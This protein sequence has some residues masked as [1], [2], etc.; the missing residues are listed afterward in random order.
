MNVC[1]YIEYHRTNLLDPK[2]PLTHPQ[3]FA[4]LLQV[5]KTKKQLD[6]RVPQRNG[7]AWLVCGQGMN[8]TMWY[9]A[10]VMTWKNN[11]H[12]GLSIKPIGLISSQ[13]ADIKGI[14]MVY[15]VIDWDIFDAYWQDIT[16]ESLGFGEK[17]WPSVTQPDRCP[18]V[19]VHALRDTL[20]MKK[21]GLVWTQRA[22]YCDLNGKHDFSVGS[23]SPT[24]WIGIQ[25]KMGFV[26]IYP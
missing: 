8:L 14:F 23:R 17:N 15:L 24:S 2:F 5:R 11:K 25:R 9:L 20:Q 22:N 6:L 13:P 4:G 10:G 21:K 26:V 7:M 19:H 1:E 16:N 12:G 18:H 3:L